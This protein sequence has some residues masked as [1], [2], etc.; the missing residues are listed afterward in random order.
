MHETLLFPRRARHGDQRRAPIVAAPRDWRD[1]GP[2]PRQA[3]RGDE[4]RFAL[5]SQMAPVYNALIVM[6]P[7]GASFPS[8]PRP[9]TGAPAARGGA[10]S[11]LVTGECDD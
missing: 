1:L 5:P 11:R 4:R 7:R 9:A 10:D 6:C 3:V 2:G 8:A